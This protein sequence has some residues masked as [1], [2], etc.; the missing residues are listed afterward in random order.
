MWSR[1]NG[2]AGGELGSFFKM[3]FFGVLCKDPLPPT[4]L[5]EALM[6]CSSNQRGS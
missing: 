1:R 2:N 6:K 3:F 5:L 4:V